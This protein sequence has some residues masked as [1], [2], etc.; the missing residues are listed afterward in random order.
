MPELVE[1]ASDELRERGPARLAMLAGDGKLSVMEGSELGG[2]QAAPGFQ[3]QVP[4]PAGPA[5]QHS[6]QLVLTA[7]THGMTMASSAT[8]PNKPSVTYRTLMGESTT[9][10]DRMGDLKA[11]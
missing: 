9:K 10:Y 1:P 5:T 8:T 7:D 3:L 11:T 6:R 4:P 2:G